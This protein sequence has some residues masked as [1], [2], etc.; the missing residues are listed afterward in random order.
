MG[1]DRRVAELATLLVIGA[2][3]GGCGK[4]EQKS[5]APAPSASVRPKTPDRLAPGELAPGTVEV[6]G[7]AA[8]KELT[9]ER[10]FPDAAHFVGQVGPE[11]LANYVRARVEAERVEIGAA[12]TVF[13]SV[14]IKGGPPDKTFRIEVLSD[15]TG[16]RLVIKDIT[17][18]P[19]VEGLSE[20][21][22]W[23]RAGL[24]P[25]GEPLDPNKLQ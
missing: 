10:R 23:R 5:A 14:R 8:P 1:R 20:E 25:K 11:Q 22:R 19:V 6:W 7:F 24:T 21:E 2:W 9:L 18:P 17:P 3:A 15:R 16:T 4:A 13:P 12:R